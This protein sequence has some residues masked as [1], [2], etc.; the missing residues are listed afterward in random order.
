MLKPV[1]VLSSLPTVLHEALDPIMKKQLQTPSAADSED[2]ILSVRADFDDYGADATSDV[3]GP[4]DDLDHYESIERLAEEYDSEIAD[5]SS[6]TIGE[7][8]DDGMFED[9]LFDD[10]DF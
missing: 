2:N 1:Q 9:D 3:P 5:D 8:F 10:E 7:D 6:D 4:F